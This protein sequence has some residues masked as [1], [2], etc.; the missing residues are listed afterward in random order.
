MVAIRKNRFYKPVQRTSLDEFRQRRDYQPP[1]FWPAAL[2]K[3]FKVDTDIIDKTRFAT[4]IGLLVL[5]SPAFADAVRLRASVRLPADAADVRLEH[6]ATLDGEALSAYR[7]G[8]PAWQDADE[9]E[10][11]E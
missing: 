3:L 1:K 11:K 6:I 10:L 5:A 9:F 8:F 7:D 4:V 2:G